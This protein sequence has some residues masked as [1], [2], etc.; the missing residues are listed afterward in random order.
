MDRG[1]QRLVNELAYHYLDPNQQ[2][3]LASGDL[4]V[5]WILFQWLDD[6]GETGGSHLL[7]GYD[8]STARR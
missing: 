3:E 8:L 2:T 6:T 5:I 1:A 4:K 7:Q